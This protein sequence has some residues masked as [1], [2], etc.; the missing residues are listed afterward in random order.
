MVV[1]PYLMLEFFESNH[2]RELEI[3]PRP[4]RPKERENLLER[5]LSI[6]VAVDLFPVSDQ[7][8]EVFVDDATVLW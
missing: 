6:V 1:I 3:Q 7:F 4:G 2:A 8:R 5:N